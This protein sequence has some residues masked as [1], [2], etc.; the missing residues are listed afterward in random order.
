MEIALSIFFMIVLIVVSQSATSDKEQTPEKKAKGKPKNKEPDYAHLDSL[1][2]FFLPIPNKHY[3]RIKEFDLYGTKAALL[4]NNG[5][6]EVCVFCI[7]HFNKQKP[8]TA[9]YYFFD[10]DVKYQI[11][12]SEPPKGCAQKIKEEI[13]KNIVY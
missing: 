3:Y 5:Y 11:W 10:Y 13:K 7:T 2:K 9:K 8:Q 1:Y 4:W 12:T 6:S